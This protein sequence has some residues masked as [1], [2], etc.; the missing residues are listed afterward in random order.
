VGRTIS[1]ER[2]G[3]NKP[4]IVAVPDNYRLCILAGPEE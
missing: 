3:L 1:N 4:G 2:A